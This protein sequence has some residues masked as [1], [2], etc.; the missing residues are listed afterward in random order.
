MKLRI[1]SIIIVLIILSVPSLGAKKKLPGD[2]YYLLEMM[3]STDVRD[4]RDAAV[5]LGVYADKSAVPYLIKGL[6]DGDNK[7]RAYSAESLGKIGDGEALEPLLAIVADPS[8]LVRRNVITALGE[9]G[10]P[11][12]LDRLA[13]AMPLEDGWAR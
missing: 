5:E 2:Y 4:R 3:N 11:A 10:D 13:E 12:A 9:I 8:S 7:V 1:Y 6:T